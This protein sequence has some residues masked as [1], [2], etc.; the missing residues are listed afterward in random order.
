MK[1]PIYAILFG[2]IERVAMR[3][4]WA[5]ALHGSMQRDMDIVLMPWT[6]DAEPDH[7]VVINAIKKAYEG[8]KDE[9]LLAT[10]KPHGRIGYTIMLDYGTHYIDISVIDTRLK[11]ATDD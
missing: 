5:L 10:K 7:L 3:F 6:E 11:E 8:F 2:H 9:K 4:G 1:A